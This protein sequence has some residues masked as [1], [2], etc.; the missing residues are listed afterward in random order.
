MGADYYIDLL[1]PVRDV[2]EAFRILQEAFSDLSYKHW[3]EEQEK[4]YKKPYSLNVQTF[5]QSWYDGN[6]KL[7]MV[8]SRDKKPLGYLVGWPFRPMSYDALT[9]SVQEW[10]TGGDKEMERA[11]FDHVAKAIRLLNCAEL[12]VPVPG[13]GDAPQISGSW[14]KQNTFSLAR[15]TKE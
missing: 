13:N 3:I 10:Y 5:A 6:L 7:F 12:V 15:Y 1:E 9:F 14:K 2:T 8:W 4:Y 11:L